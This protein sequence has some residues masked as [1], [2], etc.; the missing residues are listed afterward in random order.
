MTKHIISEISEQEELFY[1]KKMLLSTKVSL[2]SNQIKKWRNY[3]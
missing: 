1:G 2:V 3:F